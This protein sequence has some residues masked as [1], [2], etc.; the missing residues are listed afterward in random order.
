MTDSLFALTAGVVDY[1]G[2]FPPAALAM[3][4]AVEAYAHYLAD[5][6]QAMLGRFVIPVARLTEFDRVAAEH[7]PRGERS[8]PWALTALVGPD[9]AQCRQLNL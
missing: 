2:L 1:A 9:P 4:P 3:A 6:H 8:T 7:L 5:P